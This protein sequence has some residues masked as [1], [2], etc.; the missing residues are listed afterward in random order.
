MPF[1]SII[2][3]IYK[4][5]KYLDECIQSILP[6]SFTDYECVLVDDGSPDSCPAMCDEYSKKDRRIK[7]IHKEN[8]GLSDARNVGITQASGKYVVLLDSDD[9]FADNNSLENLFNV[10]QKYNV[11]VIINVNLLEFKDNGEKT[12]IDNYNKSIICASPCEIL[13]G[14]DEVPT[15]FAAWHFVVNRKHVIKNDLFFKKGLLHEDEHYMPRI[16][17]TTE[18][19]AVNH[20][21]FYAYRRARVGSITATITPKRLLS[22]LE[23]A[24]DLLEWSKNEKTYTKEGCDY[25]L[26]RAAFFCDVVY[27]LSDEIKRQDKNAYRIIC[28]KLSKI[29]ET[30]PRVMK[31]KRNTFVKFFGVDYTK[32]LEKWC[33][34][35]I[36]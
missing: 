25:M 22:Y 27:K 11:D 15:F 3:P 1:F 36:K 4:V 28:K 17:F 35:I 6:Q 21:P 2:V 20:S 5:E 19:I 23:I 12:I 29:W 13:T 14:R 7:V 32:L 8:G 34:N 24:G 10:I 31:R 16:L 33:N 26:K 18:R 9:K 30:F